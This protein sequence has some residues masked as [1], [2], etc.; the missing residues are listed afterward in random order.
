MLEEMRNLGAGLLTLGESGTNVSFDSGLQEE[1]RNVLYLPVLQLMAYYRA[2]A[3][4]LDPDQPKNLTS[5][6]E[7]DL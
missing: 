6:V 4:G 2:V 5:V 7:L 3:K 1:I